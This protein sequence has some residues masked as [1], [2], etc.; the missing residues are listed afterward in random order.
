MPIKP[1]NLVPRAEQRGHRAKIEFDQLLFPRSERC[2]GGRG[3]SLQPPV[4]ADTLVG[5]YVSHAPEKPGGDGA[6]PLPVYRGAKQRGDVPGAW[7][8]PAVAR[9]GRRSRQRSSPGCPAT[10]D[11]PSVTA[12]GRA[13]SLC[14]REPFPAGD[15]GVR[16]PHPTG[17]TPAVR[18]NTGPAAVQKVASLLKF[19]KFFLPLGVPWGKRET[20]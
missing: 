8:P 6:P 11:N 20:C 14:T 10:S 9:N 1:P 17:A 19:G 13:S 7:P 5:P 16:S 2:P 3:S 15:G 12:F 18:G 4:G